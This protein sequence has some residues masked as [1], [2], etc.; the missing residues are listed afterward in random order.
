[1]NKSIVR[2]V[3]VLFLTLISIILISFSAFAN[4][5]GFDANNINDIEE[6]FTRLKL[7]SIDEP[8]KKTSFS[9]FDISDQGNYVLGFN[10]NKNDYLLVYSSEG[11]YL[12]GFSFLDNGSFGVEWVGNNLNLYLVRSDLIVTVDSQ[13][14]CLDIKE[15]KETTENYDYWEKEI[16]ANKRTVNG[17]TYTAKHWLYNNELLH[18]GAYQ[19]LIR[20]TPSDEQVVLYNCS[21][22]SLDFLSFIVPGVIALVLLVLTITIC[23]RLKRKRRTSEMS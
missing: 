22:N 2:K 21:E 17:I 1:M 12:Y 23:K 6:L 5:V 15:I 7:E 14:N 4:D 8:A 10:N 18:W 19:E 13:G 16:Y 20:S 11:N 9:C 3:F